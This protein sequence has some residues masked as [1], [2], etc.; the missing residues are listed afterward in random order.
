MS[1]DDFTAK[2]EIA[3]IERGIR[4][5]GERVWFV[6]FHLVDETVFEEP[7]TLTVWIDAALP[8]DKLVTEAWKKAKRTFRELDRY[9]LHE[10]RLTIGP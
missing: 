3:R 6:T 4:R 9:A 1:S 10:S 5:T 2:I 8:L 7:V